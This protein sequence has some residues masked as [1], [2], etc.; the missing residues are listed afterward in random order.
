LST[1]VESNSS[2]PEDGL[3]P[4]CSHFASI[5]ASLLL[6]PYSLCLVS[7]VGDDRIQ[8]ALLNWIYVII[9]LC[10]VGAGETWAREED[11]M[12][13]GFGDQLPLL[14]PLI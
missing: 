11:V 3:V 9:S 14:S 6:S 5:V 13:R 12:Y 7:V 2:V 1:L 10:R 4:S 8:T